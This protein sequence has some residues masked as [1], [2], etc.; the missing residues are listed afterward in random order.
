VLIAGGIGITP[1][2]AM[3]QTLKARGTPFNLHYSGRTPAEMA[4]RDRLAIEFPD[5]LHLYFTR[6]EGGNRPDIEA[7]LDAVTPDTMFYVCGPARL[8]EAVI[9][10]AR[11]LAIP[12]SRLQYESF[13]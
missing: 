11:K 12:S 6:T 9:E 10:A 4:Y 8:I 2:K 1:I 7:I 13:E 3:A 5:H